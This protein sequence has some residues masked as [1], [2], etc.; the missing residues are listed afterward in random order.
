MQG[1]GIWLLLILGFLLKPC[2]AQQSPQIQLDYSQNPEWFPRIYKP[3]QMQKIPEI[4]LINSSSLRQLIFD[5]K[6]RISLP[7]LKAAVSENNLDVLSST[8]NA[9][10]AQTDLL[11][12]KGGGAPRGGGGARIPSG[13][14]AGA[15]GA[16]VEGF[17]GLGGFGS[18]G[19]ITGGARQVRAFPRGSYDPSFALGLS[20]DK[21]TSPLNT[22]VVSGLPDVTTTS[23]A[24]QTRYSQSFTTGSSISISFNNMRQRSTQKYLLYN[25]Y[26]VSQFSVIF[27]Q[28]LLSGFG[29][30]SGRRFLEVAK[31]EE[32]IMREN[33]RLQ[34]STT[35][36]R[37][38]NDYWDLVSAH[39]NVRVAEQS[40]E[41]A[42]QFL[43]NTKKREEIGALS[44][45]DVMSA[46]SELAARQRDL[47]AAQTRTQMHEVDLKNAISKDIKPILDVVKVEP[48]DRLPEP[49]EDD[50]PKLEDAL[51]IALSRRPEILKAE[52]DILNQEVAVKY[53]KDLMRPSL[54]FFAMFNSSGLYGNRIQEGSSAILPGGLSQAIHQ[55]WNWRYPEYA[56]GFSFSINIRNRSAKADSYRAKWEKQQSELALQRTRNN[57]EIE[58]RKALI[59]L[60]QTKAEIEAAHKAVELSSAVFAAEEAKLMEGVSTPYELMRRQRDL[61]SAQFAEVRARSNY[62]KALVE[63]DRSMGILDPHSSD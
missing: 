6:L 37:A 10:F 24:L 17:G 54:L 36:A 40:L 41:L 13:L 43:E 14:F 15:I 62:A 25:P 58:V 50:I 20:V 7:Q 57:I 3:Y 33:V 12:V 45:M 44:P 39:E 32:R 38:Q 19:G 35:L 42:R 29:F 49:K 8:N 34:A 61:R 22:V 26:V 52:A 55:V 30:D 16:G 11:R 28:Q 21:T 23:V 31:N 1:A 4:Q 18:A 60:T 2:A 47:V 27:T 59:G 51:K 5:G 48:S 56:V 53:A 9:L 46:E 63:R